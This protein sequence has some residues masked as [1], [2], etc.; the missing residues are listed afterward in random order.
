VFAKD[1]IIT[2]SRN[3]KVD[4]SNIPAANNLVCKG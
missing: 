2:W 4:T 3:D 1:E